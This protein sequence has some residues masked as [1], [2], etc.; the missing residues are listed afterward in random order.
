MS[1]DGATDARTPCQRGLDEA[2]R[3][4]CSPSGATASRLSS[5]ALTVP[6]ALTCVAVAAAQASL[7][8]DPVSST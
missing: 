8:A 4:A 5:S 1:R 2:Q 3:V 7:E 6:F